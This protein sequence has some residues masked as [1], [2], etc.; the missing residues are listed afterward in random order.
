MQIVNSAERYGFLTKFLHWFIVLLFAFQYFSGHLMMAMLHGNWQ[1]TSKSVVLGLGMNNW[2]N[3]H[4]SIGLVV[5]AIVVLRL[6]NRTFTR[7][8]DWAPKLTDGEKKAIHAYEWL[9]YLGMAIMPLSG[10]VYT[11]ASGY[12]VYLFEVY[13]LPNPIGKWK[14]LGETAKWVHI[15]SAWVIVA[16]LAAHLFVVLR[17]QFFVRDNLF[18]RM[19]FG[20]SD[21]T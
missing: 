1:L 19:W 4:K 18:G 10:F 13:N 11:M 20:H 2:F 15:V 17:H 6:L 9:L 8:P 21:S 5:L 7:L 12:G 14:A 3:W 16:A